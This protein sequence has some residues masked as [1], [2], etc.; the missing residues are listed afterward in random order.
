M[1][2]FKLVFRAAKVLQEE[3]YACLRFNFRGV[4]LSAGVHD[5]GRGEQDDVRAGIGW[6][7][8]RFPGAPLVLGGFSFGAA[9]ALRVGVDEPGIAGL[10]GLG[11]PLATVGDAAFLERAR[12]PLLIVQGERDAFGSGAAVAALPLPPTARVLVVPGADHF[13]GG[14]EPVVFESL[15][16]FI[17]ALPGLTPPQA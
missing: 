6:L 12:A 9:M 8:G 10:F 7:R 16:R 13:F 15:Q 17:A 5:D 11:F 2:H 14:H 3:G 1:M 4:G